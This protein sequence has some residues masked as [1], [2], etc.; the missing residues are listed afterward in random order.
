MWLRLEL[1]VLPRRLAPVFPSP[2]SP[3]FLQWAKDFP[4][5]KI[6]LARF[7]TLARIAK[8]S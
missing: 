7:V 8:D 1:P 3:T 6:T 4:I 5:W 2:S